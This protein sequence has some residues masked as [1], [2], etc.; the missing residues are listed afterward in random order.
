MYLDEVL[1]QNRKFVEEESYIPYQTDK[2]PDKRI[3]V[4]SCMDTRLVEL[5]PRALNVKNGD[6]KMVKNAGAILTHP[7]GSVMR[8][9]MVA[10]YELQADEIF[11][12]GHH[13]CGM[14]H[15]NGE[16]TISKMK[17]QG[18]KDEVFE[19]L[20]YAGV[21]VKNW[22]QGFERVEDSVQNSVDMVRNHPLLP[23]KTPVHGLVIDPGTG[24]LDLVTRGYE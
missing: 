17:E 6:I 22:L 9:L 24:R 18:V 1:E 7:F 13:D 4:L 8:S 10:V 3:V 16:Q 15:Y 19:T 11:I 23:K 2:F 14:K 21:D 12:I 5:L 20:E